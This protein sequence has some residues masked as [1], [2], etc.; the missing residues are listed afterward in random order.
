MRDLVLSSG[1]HVVV[2]FILRKVEGGSVEP[3]YEG[4][5]CG[6]SSLQESVG[7]ESAYDQS[8]IF[9]INCMCGTTF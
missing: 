8:S 9:C 7:P 4:L 2:G 3:E 6:G 1:H 5:F